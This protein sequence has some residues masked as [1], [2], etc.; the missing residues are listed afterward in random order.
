[1]TDVRA[2]TEGRSDPG[3]P[4]HEIDEQ[5]RRACADPIAAAKAANTVI[6]SLDLHER[7]G[8]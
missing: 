7:S 1:V 5:V 8:E 4:R 6:N 3:E 2:A